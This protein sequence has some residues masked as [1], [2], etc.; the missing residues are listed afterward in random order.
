MCTH[1]VHHV[2]AI[3]TAVDVSVKMNMVEV[4]VMSIQIAMQVSVCS[5]S[6]CQDGCRKCAHIVYMCVYAICTLFVQ[7]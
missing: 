3:C 7:L 4:T 5:I 1:S 2:Y 6:T